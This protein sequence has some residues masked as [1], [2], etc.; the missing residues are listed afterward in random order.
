MRTINSH[1]TMTTV[2][3][4]KEFLDTLPQDLPVKI[5]REQLVPNGTQIVWDDLCVDPDGNC[6]FADNKNDINEHGLWLGTN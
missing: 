6:C 5:L 2:A 1:I 4:L 3:Q